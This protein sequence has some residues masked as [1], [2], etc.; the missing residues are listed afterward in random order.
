MISTDLVLQTL[1]KQ[2]A[3]LYLKAAKFN[4][5]DIFIIN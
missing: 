4:G 5:L 1:C 2:C 3:G